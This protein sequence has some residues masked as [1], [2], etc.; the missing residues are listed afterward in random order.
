MLSTLDPLHPLIRI[1]AKSRDCGME[2][3]GPMLA[4]FFTSWVRVALGLVSS[5]VLHRK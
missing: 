2:L 4:L 3:L 5:L 1:V